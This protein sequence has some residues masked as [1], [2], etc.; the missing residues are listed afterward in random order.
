MA[1]I[2]LPGK[3]LNTIQ[4]ELIA[5]TTR[6]II[7]CRNILSEKPCS[8]GGPRWGLGHYLNK[9]FYNSQGVTFVSMPAKK[10]LKQRFWTKKHLFF[11]HTKK[12][13]KPL[14]ISFFYGFPKLYCQGHV[15]Q[16]PKASLHWDTQS[17]CLRVTRPG[18]DLTSK[19]GICP[20]IYTAGFSG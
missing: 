18:N 14:L 9:V 4:S 5:W 10:R 17:V 16:A 8:F 1:S 20:K 3:A 19:H 6:L 13:R 12:S 11:A 7:A 15:N 2:T